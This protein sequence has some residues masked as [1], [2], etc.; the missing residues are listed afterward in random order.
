VAVIAGGNRERGHWR[1]CAKL[2]E[3]DNEPTRHTYSV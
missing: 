2:A 1:F 3:G